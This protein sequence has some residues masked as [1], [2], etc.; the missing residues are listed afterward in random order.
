MIAARK[1]GLVIFSNKEIVDNIIKV[2][3]NKDKVFLYLG[4]S[5]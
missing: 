2:E 4:E 5:K 3:D 1:Q